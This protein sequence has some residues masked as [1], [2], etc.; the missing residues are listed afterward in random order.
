M[1]R[2]Y[3]SAIGAGLGLAVMS[4]PLA[5]AQQYQNH[6]DMHGMAPMHTMQ[7]HGEQHG[8][9]HPVQ[10]HP[11]PMHHVA[12]HYVGPVHVQVP[13][14]GGYQP[15]PVTYAG[16]AWHNGNHYTGGRVVVSD[17]QMR[18][19]HQPPHGYEWVQSNGQ[20]VMIAVASG[21]IADV[22]VNALVH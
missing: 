15:H 18:H 14:H 10:V 1:K 8:P 13:M 11:M 17:W 6:D 3:L 16:H 19:L 2:F 7:Q 22:V 4:G 21:V 9:M 5:F 12:P 20:Y